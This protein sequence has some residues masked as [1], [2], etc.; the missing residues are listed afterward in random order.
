[1]I[2]SY[3]RLYA[4]F[5]GIF[6]ASSLL[7]ADTSYVVSKKIIYDKKNVS[8][9]EFGAKGDGQ[10]D[11]TLS[12]M[13]AAEKAYRLKVPFEGNNI[14]KVTTNHIPT[15]SNI[16][17]IGKGKF[18]VEIRNLKGKIQTDEF[19]IDPKKNTVTTTLF[20][21]NEEIKTIIGLQNRYAAFPKGVMNKRGE[22]LYTYYFGIKHVGGGPSEARALVSRDKGQTWKDYFIVG[23]LTDK[24]QGFSYA[25]DTA[26]GIT[27]DGKYLALISISKDG[28]VERYR[29]VSQDGVFWSMPKKIH[30]GDVEG[31]L[32]A[33]VKRDPITNDPATGKSE[34]VFFGNI[35]SL[36]SGKL[37]VP[38]YIANTN[39]VAIND[40]GFGK[41]WNLKLIREHS[42][43]LRIS[44]M[45]IGIISENEM[46]AIGRVDGQVSSM[47]QFYTQDGGDS[48][49]PQG[50]TN[51]NSN[52]GNLPQNIITVV[53]NSMKYMDL[54][55][56]IRTSKSA[57]SK[58]AHSYMRERILAS[59]VRKTSKKWHEGIYIKNL[60]VDE[61][62]NIDNDA[63]RDYYLTG[64]DDV[65]SDRCLVIFHEETRKNESK[66]N[67]FT[68]K[69]DIKNINELRYNLIVKD[70]H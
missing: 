9:E 36:P 6:L 70:L 16:V 53:K 61:K 3:F 38:A 34:I 24:I 13:K 32:Y 37:V 31:S 67:F 68:Y 30:F 41:I 60:L 65:L 22:I 52:G 12:V 66:I 58:Y 21:M 45:A 39:W 54:E 10:R 64:I 15:L 49:I 5:Y 56:G 43:G 46:I 55:V 19:F 28:N 62:S 25:Y 27:K 35:K 40:D 8:P 69:S 11:D 17:R 4:F 63:N 2:T 20:N 1:M 33:H 26:I 50:Y 57:L 48:W 44:E 59:D 7:Y 14:Y 51:L 29:T 18:L 23:N 47:F 42:D